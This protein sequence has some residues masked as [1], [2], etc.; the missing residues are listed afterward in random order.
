MKKFENCLLVSDI[1]GTLMEMG[2][3]NPKNLAAI[4]EFI[5]LGGTFC[6]AT[7]RCVPAIE[8]IV[9]NFKNLTHAIVYNGGMIYDYTKRAPIMERTLEDSDKEFFKIL[10]ER[11]PELG[12]EIYCGNDL[13][14]I[15]W[16]EA[17]QV[18]FDYERLS[19]KMATYEQ[20]EKL[21]WNKAMC[22]Y[23]ADF[24]ETEIDKLIN[25]FKGVNC[26]YTRAAFSINGVDYRGYEQLPGGANKGFALGKLSS[27]LGIPSGK[28]F[29]IGDYYNDTAMLKAADI[30]ACPSESPE[31]IKQLVDFVG[32]ACRDG[33]VADFIEYLKTANF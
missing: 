12:V 8:H 27:L 18:H 6:I 22:Y 30:S 5:S 15:N 2:Y 1:D 28:T 16:S 25:E 23:K 33:A 7:G 4:E 10:L 17:C 19:Y 29:A 14:M 21:K 32:C 11:I 20:L 31:D 26:E 13:Y 3:I 9:C 24:S